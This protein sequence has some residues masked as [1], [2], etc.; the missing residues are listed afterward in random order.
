M[1]LTLCN[2]DAEDYTIKLK[3][4]NS[5]TTNDASAKKSEESE[6]SQ[7]YTQ[8]IR[9]T[10]DFNRP[11]TTTIDVQEVPI[12]IKDDN[13][14]V[15]VQLYEPKKN[16]NGVSSEYGLSTESPKHGHH[17]DLAIESDGYIGVAEVGNSKNAKHI[18]DTRYYYEYIVKQG[19]T[20]SG[21]ASNFH[22]TPDIL[23]R[24]IGLESNTVPKVGSKLLIPTQHY[25]IRNDVV[26]IPVIQ[27]LLTNH[28][29]GNKKTLSNITAQN[30]PNNPNIPMP[31]R[32][33]GNGGGEANVPYV[34]KKNPHGDIAIP[35]DAATTK[36]KD[37]DSIE[38]F[39]MAASN[40]AMFTWP[41]T[42]RKILV[43]FVDSTKSSGINIESIEGSNIVSVGDGVVAYVGNEIPSYG[44][45]LMIKHAD[46]Y[47][48]VYGHNKTIMVK[49]GDAVKRGQV[50]AK[51]GKTGAVKN[52]QL[53]FS[54]RHNRKIMNPMEYLSK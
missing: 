41:V 23:V 7:S 29:P 40:D 4:G 22:T 53:F 46:G 48:S 6:N 47:V 50:V 5:W 11:S 21:I 20:L 13:K 27:V 45:L 42:S 37:R 54:V 28:S 18:T 8:P 2:V 39:S 19:D 31:H 14:D 9:I 44:E 26:I 15:P 49:K 30:Y 38:D 25:K 3:R 35:I 32:K 34:E 51:V 12:E 10:K 43:P 17:K 33:K 16:P 36:T 24:T 1:I 52:S